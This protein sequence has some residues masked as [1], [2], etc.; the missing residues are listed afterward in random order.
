MTFRAKNAG[1]ERSRILTV[2]ENCHATSENRKRAGFREIL[3]EA[4]R[5]FCAR[6][7]W[8]VSLAALG[9]G[10]CDAQRPT[11]EPASP[12]FSVNWHPG[13]G[14]GDL[15]DLATVQIPEGL[16]FADA[17]G[18]TSL[19]LTMGNPITGRE[20]GVI[21]PQNGEWLIVFE[22]Q[23]AGHVSREQVR[24]IS[25]ETLIMAVETEN[26]KL[27]RQR[28]SRGWPEFA[29][30][31]WEERPR[32]DSEMN[33]LTWAFTGR[34][35]SN[36]V[37]AQNVRLFGRSGF[38]SASWLGPKRSESAREFRQILTRFSFKAGRQYADFTP[39]EPVASRQIEEALLGTS[40]PESPAKST[41]TPQTTVP[42]REDNVRA[43]YAIYLGWIFFGVGL[44]FFVRILLRR[45]SVR[46]PGISS[47]V[48]F[49]IIRGI[50]LVAPPS[51]L[52]IFEYR[53]RFR[54]TNPLDAQK[55]IPQR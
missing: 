49:R 54:R 39:G 27:N 31:H 24:N 1:G 2:A 47:S 4:M 16:L 3:F 48:F 46:N 8:T 20:T 12:S 34:T 32:F 37:F 19:L 9:T 13:P 18:A 55:E 29:I 26:T 10:T 14:I 40:F 51:R 33:A 43:R 44:T 42:D 11:S 21:A 25:A 35:G 17:K 7:L 6:I 23:E 45:L 22:F 15:R 36:P 41:A 50:L 53:Q 5:L 30:D 52:E 28:K 38:M